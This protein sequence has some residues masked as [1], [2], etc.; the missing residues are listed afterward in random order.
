MS[1]P[2]PSPDS[3]FLAI[4]FA[5]QEATEFRFSDEAARR[6]IALRDGGADEAAIAAELALEPEAVHALVR[7]DEA[8]ATAHRIAT[9]EEPMYPPPPP[10]LRVADARRGTAWVPFAVLI[11]ILLGAGVYALGR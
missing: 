8:Q 2:P 5:G 7:A 10:H 9:G 11:L 4:R 3:R 1:S 6:F